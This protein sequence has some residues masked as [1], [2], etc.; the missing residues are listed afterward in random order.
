MNTTN[1]PTLEA[2]SGFFVAADSAYM[3][4]LKDTDAGYFIAKEPVIKFDAFNASELVEVLK[5]SLSKP[6]DVIAAEHMPPKDLVM[7]PYISVSTQKQL[8]QKTV[9]ISIKRL[10]TGF[11]IESP[12]KSSDGTTDRKGPKA[13][14]TVLPPETTYEQLAAVIIEHLKSRKDL[15]GSTVDFNQPKTAKGA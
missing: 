3:P 9:Y 10:D 13:I 15:P 8:E 4:T 2:L 7:A 14:D 6:N 12:R 11:R 5:H 1:K